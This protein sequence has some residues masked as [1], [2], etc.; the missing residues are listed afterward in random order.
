VKTALGS[1]SPTAPK[2]PSWFVAV[3]DLG[4]ATRWARNRGNARGVRLFVREWQLASP[5]IVF[6]LPSPLSP[7]SFI[8]GG[9][10]EAGKQD[11]KGSFM[12]WLQTIYEALVMLMSCL[13]TRSLIRVYIGGLSI[14]TDGYTNTRRFLVRCLLSP[15]NQ[16]L[17]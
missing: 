1:Q 3:R 15:C 12:S 8:L 6:P 11:A 7:L 5:E 17:N 2:P 16:L 4:A 9:N 14:L 13:L 10:L